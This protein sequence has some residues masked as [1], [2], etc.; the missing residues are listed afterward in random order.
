MWPL[1]G[2]FLK[3]IVYWT[4]SLG[5]VYK[6]CAG[7]CFFFFFL[8]SVGGWG[9]WVYADFRAVVCAVERMASCMLRFVCRLAFQLGGPPLDGVL[10]F[11][12]RTVQPVSSRYTDYSTRVD[13]Y[14]RWIKISTEND[15]NMCI[16]VWF[17]GSLRTARPRQFVPASQQ[18][19]RHCNNQEFCH[20]RNYGFHIFPRTESRELICTNTW[21]RLENPFY[22]LVK[23][24]R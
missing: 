5:T 20:S 13:L 2:F 9:G 15:K 17:R 6:C 22:L 24:C 4:V 1:P 12:S 21:F 14:S 11:D 18:S 16:R 7:A 8:L 19:R 3:C 10:K 23:H